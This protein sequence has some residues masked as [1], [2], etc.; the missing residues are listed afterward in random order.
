[1]EN[2]RKMAKKIFI[3][4]NR[5]KLFVYIINNA[6]PSGTTDN[7]NIPLAFCQLHFCQNVHLRATLKLSHKNVAP[8]ASQTTI[9]SGTKRQE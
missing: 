9:K 3:S 8:S 6:V 4:G 5:E 7:Y 1:M 2:K